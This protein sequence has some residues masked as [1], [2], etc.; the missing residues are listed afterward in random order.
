MNEA[1]RRMSTRKPPACAAKG[2]TD[3]LSSASSVAPDVAAEDL[4][5]AEEVSWA[6]GFITAD[7]FH[8]PLFLPP[9]G[10]S[11]DGFLKPQKQN[12]RKTAR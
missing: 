3:D 10:E 7:G 1:E 2:S 9:D 11:V 4:S 5:G 8:I 6:D 12:R